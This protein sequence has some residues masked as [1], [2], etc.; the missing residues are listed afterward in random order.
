MVS[1]GG[2][3]GGTALLRKPEFLLV[4]EAETGD[5]E[6]G[7]TAGM[8]ISFVLVLLLLSLL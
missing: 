3:V 4:V 8:S 6:V 7:G 5:R 2:Q 1:I